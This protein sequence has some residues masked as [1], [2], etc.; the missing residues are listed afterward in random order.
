MKRFLYSALLLLISL[1]AFAQTSPE[2]DGY[3]REFPQRAGFNTHSYEFLP[4][5][6]TPAP[7]GFKPF[8]ISHYGRHGSRSHGNDT[9]LQKLK[10]YLQTASN[11]GI[12]TPAGDT[13][14]YYTKKVLELH[15]GM[16]GR[17]T[18]RGAREHEQLA[19]RMYQRY[20]AVFRNGEVHALSSVVPRCLVSMAAFTSTL[21]SCKSDLV[22]TW[23]AG[24]KYQKFI[25]R[26]CPSAVKEKARAIVHG[27]LTAVQVD[28]MAAYSRIF[29]DPERG[30][31]IFKKPYRLFSYIY[32]LA[33]ITEAF[34]IEEN[35]F[36]F[37]PWEVVLSDYNSGALSAYLQQCNSEPFGDERMPRASN[38][39]NE[40]VRKAD[41]A[42]A[43][44][45][46]AADL[47][48]GHD[49]PFLGICSY[50][51]LE[52]YGYP[53]LTAEQA[54]GNWNGA[55]L[56]PYAA[57]LQLIFYRNRKGMVLVKFLANEQETLIPEL[58][59]YSGPYY[60][61]VDV[62]N[63]IAKRN[64]SNTMK[65]EEKTANPKG[66]VLEHPAIDVAD[67][68]ATA[69]W[70]CKNLGFTITL[71]KDDE[72]HTTFIVDGSGRVAIEL[73]RAKTQ[74]KAPDYANMD[75]LTLHF[76]F[77]ST[78]VDAD[79]ERLTKAGAT[80]VSHD[81]SPGFDGAMM[82][83]PSGIPIQFVKREKSILLK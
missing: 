21:K 6:D 15:D 39:A 18:P 2:L 14:F 35:L 70:W 62:K 63:F 27:P 10:S 43:G 36:R 48:F 26:A 11:E 44:A 41:E 55:K 65:K 28:T 79:I 52:G 64:T 25:T 16:G 58:E 66:F 47:I 31:A 23:D 83:D 5:K 57:N 12:L 33:R 56:C 73:Y 80:L 81:K 37:L 20:P 32:S 68:I 76:G 59:A 30:K 34:D 67:P 74:P 69:E 54:Y 42:I 60:K 40:M 29:T 71:Q 72:A 61:W 4:I 24:E 50:F 8:Y 78:D 75:P 19:R 45:P 77:T 3:L 13:I 82:R 22:I 46:V 49:W 1:A 7:G 9:S 17:L 38:L 51:G 53:R